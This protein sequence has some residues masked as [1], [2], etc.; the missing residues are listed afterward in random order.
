MMRCWEDIPNIFTLDVPPIEWMVEG[1]LPRAS[2]TLLAGEPGSYKMWLA[3]AL[4]RG[5]ATG[6]NFLGRKCVQANVLYLDRENPLV[7]M[8]ERLRVL[9]IEESAEANCR[10]WGGWFRSAP[11]G[12]G[13]IRLLEIAHARRPLM[14]FDSLIRFHAAADENSAT[15]MA[16]VMADL[17]A[18][19]NAGATVVVLHHKQ[20][21]KGRPIAG[22]ATLPEEWTRRWPC[23]KIGKLACCVLNVSR[24]A[25]LRNF[26]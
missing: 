15:E 4:L 3:L 16:V 24:A 18:L 25:S 19:A 2:A 12:I 5:V 13:D 9:G 6:R 17:R 14:V 8:R 22:R 1:I 21:P 23:R 20:N 7:V 11:P 26:R 10:I